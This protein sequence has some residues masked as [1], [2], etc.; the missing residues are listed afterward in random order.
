M[1]VNKVSWLGCQPDQATDWLAY[2]LTD[3]SIDRMIRILQ[4]FV[5]QS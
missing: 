4:S 3:P 2:L 1:H 5:Q